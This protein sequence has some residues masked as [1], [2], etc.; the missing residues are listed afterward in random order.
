MRA[1]GGVLAIAGAEQ[2]IAFAGIVLD[3]DAATPAAIRAAL[4]RVLDAD[5]YRRAARAV[6]DSIAELPTA[7]ALLAGILIE[8][9]TNG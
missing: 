2:P 7:D 5:S 1:C 4:G 3:P 9:R 6:A 8:R